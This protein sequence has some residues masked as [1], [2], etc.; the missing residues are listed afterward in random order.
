MDRGLTNVTRLSSVDL[1]LLLLVGLLVLLLGVDIAVHIIFTDLKGTG[2]ASWVPLIVKVNTTV[3]GIG[4]VFLWLW[5]MTRDDREM[6]RADFFRR[7]WVLA[8]VV[9]VINGTWHYFRVWLPLVLQRVHHYSLEETQWFSVAYYV[10]TFLGSIAAGFVTLLLAKGGLPVHRS[11]MLVFSSC[12]LICMLSVVAANLPAG[13][14]LLGLFLIIGFAALG[15]FPNY[16]SFTQELTV[17]HQGKLTGALGCVCWLAM[18]LLHEVVGDS[19]ERTHSYTTSVAVAGLVP[20]LAVAALVLFW[21]KTVVAS[22]HLVS[23]EGGFTPKLNGEAI[24][25][26]ASIGVQK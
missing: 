19:I 1:F 14:L 23:V 20:L 18:S 24:Q 10:A 12:A 9:V 2:S 16:Y 22:S 21:G 11:R 8:L 26:S 6:N 7:F 25:P 13:P 5:L 17:R 15:M 3:I 4:G